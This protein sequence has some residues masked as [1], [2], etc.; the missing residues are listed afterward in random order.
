ME[1]RAL[2]VA[3]LVGGVWLT[4]ASAGEL[5]SARREMSWTVLSDGRVLIAGGMRFENGVGGP[6]GEAEC[7][8]PI[9][10]RSRAIQTPMNQPR[11]G[12][13]MTTLRDG[14]VLVTGGW[15]HYIGQP[16]DPEEPP[17]P[18][19]LPVLLNSAELFDPRT[20]TWENVG[21]LQSLGGKGY[22]A[23]L[24]LDGRVLFVG[25]DAVEIYSPSTK[26]FTKLSQPSL[27][28]SNPRLTL[29]NSGN[30]LL[31]GHA[32]DGVA[33]ELFDPGTNSFRKAGVPQ[34]SRTGDYT[35]TKLRDGRVLLAGGDRDNSQKGQLEIFDPLLGQFHLAGAM[36]TARDGHTATLSPGGKVLLAGGNGI[37]SW[38]GEEGAPVHGALGTVERFDPAS[39]TCEAA[40]NMQ[41]ARYAHGAVLTHQG[42]LALFGGENQTSAIKSVETIR[43]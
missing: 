22:A 25:W 42:K 37:V 10:G 26:T 17:H 2:L 19:P 7:L 24:L 35:A 29:L 38:Q 40:G 36:G 41:E 33:A 20:E 43:P 39:A 13:T 16:H 30:V 21:S 34:V 31:T 23:L 18:P 9:T 4:A 27:P 32:G 11:S 8:D 15:L 5:L 3:S 14:R 1:L 28:R 6:T 12:H